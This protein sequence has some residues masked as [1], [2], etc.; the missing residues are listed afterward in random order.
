MSSTFRS[1]PA[2]DDRENDPTG[3]VAFLL[4][5]WLTTSD[6]PQKTVVQLRVN[7]VEA[8]DAVVLVSPS[9]VLAQVADLREAGLS[10]FTG[11]RTVIDQREYVSLSSL[12][13][14]VTYSFNQAELVLDLE[15][16]AEVLG[17]K[18]VDVG[19]SRPSDIEYPRNASAF[20]NYALTRRAGEGSDLFGETGIS[21]A[22]AL[23]SASIS[24][25]AGHLRRGPAALTIDDR[26]RLRR[27]ILGEILPQSV[28]GV[29]GLQFLGVG[30][31]RNFDLDP[32]FIRFPGVEL[33]AAV[34]TP[35]TLEVYVNDRLVREMQVAPGQLDIRDLPIVH[36]SGS[37]R[38]LLRDSF[39]REREVSSR[40]YV[41]NR[42]LARGTSEYS[43]N[44]GIVQPA[45]GSFVRSYGPIALSASHRT[46]ITDRLTVGFHADARPGLING[47]P[48]MAVRLA[49]GEVELSSAASSVR[50]AGGGAA[51]L[52]YQYRGHS[53]ALGGIAR[54]R[55]EHSPAFD[56]QART[57]PPVWDASVFAN[58]G[59][60]ARA[61]ASFEYR[62]SQPQQKP[63]A[64]TAAILGSIRISSRAS[65]V[66]SATMT[67]GAGGRRQVSASV[68]LSYFTGNRSLASATATFDGGVAGTSVQW[69][70]SLPTAGRGAGY[71]IAGQTG[72]TDQWSARLGYQ[73]AYGRYELGQTT[74]DGIGSASFSA[75]GGVVAIGGRVYATQ[76]VQQGFGL[77]RLRGLPGVRAYFENQ[78][79]GR[80]DARGDLVLPTLLPYYGN[81]IRIAADELPVNTHIGAT[82]KLVA[83]SYRGGAIISF[84]IARIQAISGRVVVVDAAGAR[85]PPSSG[86]LIVTAVGT[87]ISPLG[88]D[89][90]FYFE[91]LPPGQY[92]A[93]V[94]GSE[95]D[96]AFVLTIPNSDDPFLK[97]GT[98]ACVK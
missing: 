51:W 73:D 22:G 20:V 36:G 89:G 10:G 45:P 13:P 14:A 42:N 1:R 76:P 24:R 77:L 92:P 67:T 16:R 97:L 75:S 9:D 49:R 63:K 56:L 17:Q 98:V 60:G 29:G 87:P 3:A 41:G 71:T 7:H 28:L 81:R 83:P 12:A 54:A 15:A 65:V 93:R 90:E 70:R 85:L 46:G 79:V 32:Y 8:G 53:F 64:H 35:S 55:S 33:S 88:T 18:T 48:T 62:V 69:D 74:V 5:L 38:L 61:T 68:G 31:S 11:Q 59:F 50:G 96:C 37:V 72:T 44:V 58:R 26:S 57:T 6:G 4:L 40:Y 91:N 66:Q 47:G 86:D 21:V 84:P 95:R 82:E 43:Y 94:E 78:E 25:A 23:L 19:S 2:R 39:G 30:V 27:W 34:E 80:T 52:A